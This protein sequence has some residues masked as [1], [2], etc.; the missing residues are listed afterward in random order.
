[1]LHV[2]DSLMLCKCLTSADPFNKVIREAMPVFPSPLCKWGNWGPKVSFGRLTTIQKSLWP[3]TSIHWGP[4]AP[5]EEEEQHVCARHFTYISLLLS[6]SS[7]LSSHT[8]FLAVP[9]TGQAPPTSQLL[10]LL[11][12][13][14]DELP[15]STHRAASLSYFWPLVK[16]VLCEV[17]PDRSS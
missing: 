6:P 15:P 4:I 13:A 2:C 10:P 1:M 7:F 3:S 16:Y 9:P 5:Q 11:I 8:G 14:W 17:C 12:S